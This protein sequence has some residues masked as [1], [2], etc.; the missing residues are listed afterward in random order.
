MFAGAATFAVA[1]MTRQ[2]S[3]AQPQDWLTPYRWRN[4]MSDPLL[5]VL[6]FEDVLHT[7]HGWLGRAVDV[8]VLGPREASVVASYSGILDITEEFTSTAPGSS[9]DQ[10]VFYMED[11]DAR[12]HVASWD[13]EGARAVD[14]LLAID[15]AGVRLL[16]EVS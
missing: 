16:L 10:V 13:F 1:G 6:S 15:V 5:E 11:T 4:A 3:D 2:C 12:F 9:G 8:T 14:R 7:L